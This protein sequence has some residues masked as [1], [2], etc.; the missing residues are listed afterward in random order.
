MNTNDK[1]SVSPTLFDT[2]QSSTIEIEGEYRAHNTM[3]AKIT[4]SPGFGEASKTLLM[5][6]GEYFKDVTDDGNREPDSDFMCYH[7]R[8][9]ESDSSSYPLASIK[10]YNDADITLIERFNMF[11]Y[12]KDIK[13]ACFKTMIEKH[14]YKTV[15]KGN[16][17]TDRY[18]SIN[19]PLTM[20][21]FK[22]EKCRS[23]FDI[24]SINYT[25]AKTQSD[26]SK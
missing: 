14:D 18:S 26:K 19:V 24:A 10:R 3:D 15:V 13:T 20:D 12:I 4:L 9:A 6:C 11:F 5:S 23:P 17:S 2:T 21:M 16:T 8:I 25:Y 7:F 22:M 1:N